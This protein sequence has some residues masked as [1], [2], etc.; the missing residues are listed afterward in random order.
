MKISIQDLDLIYCQDKKWR[1]LECVFL[2]NNIERELEDYSIRNKNMNIEALK[3]LIYETF[4]KTS[5]LAY[6]VV[7]S[8]VIELSR[9]LNMNLKYIES[10][11]ICQTL[12]LNPILMTNEQKVELLNFLIQTV[13]DCS[14]L[15]GLD[16]VPC[17]DLQ[18]KNFSG[19]K[20]YFIQNK[21]ELDLFSCGSDSIL[22]DDSKLNINSR[23]IFLNWLNESNI[24][25]VSLFKG[26]NSID[27]I[28]L[29][30]RSLEAAK[31]QSSFDSKWLNDIWDYIN[32]HYEE[33]SL[34]GLEN[35]NLLSKKHKTT[36]LL[37]FFS[38]RA[39]NKQKYFY[40]KP[41]D[42]EISSEF[43][44]FLELNI[45]EIIIFNDMPQSFLNHP[46]RNNYVND[47]SL[48][49]FN[50][51][52]KHLYSCLNKELY[53][54]IS[55]KMSA[56]CKSSLLENLNSVK[57]ASFDMDFVKI[58]LDFLPI[59]NCFNQGK[60]FTAKQCNY[61]MVPVAFAAHL[62]KLNL[63]PDI[64]MLDTI[65]FKK[66]SANLSPLKEYPLERLIIE[67]IEYNIQRQDKYSVKELF[68]FYLLNF[69]PNS[70]LISQRPIFMDKENNWLKLNQY[71]EPNDKFVQLMVP[72][73]FL[74]PADLSIEPYY[75]KIK[76]RLLKNIELKY[77]IKFIQ[78]I[79]AQTLNKREL[80]KIVFDLIS[81]QSNKE[82]LLQSTLNFEWLTSLKDSAKLYKSSQL[83]SADFKDLVEL[84]EPLVDNHLIPTVFH[85]ILK[86]KTDLNPELVFR[87][88]SLMISSSTF[89]LTKMTKHYD[90]FS[91]CISSQLLVQKFEEK[92]YENFIYTFESFLSY[93]P[94][95]C[96]VLDFPNGCSLSPYLYS[97]NKSQNEYISKFEK[98]YLNVF[99]VL[100][101]VTLEKLIEIL[102]KIKTEPHSKRSF[103]MVRNIL[104][105]IKSTHLSELLDN[106]TLMNRLLLPVQID[107]S[108]SEK[109]DL[110][111]C[112][113]CVYS[114]EDGNSVVDQ[115][116][117]DACHEKELKLVDSRFTDVKFLKQID[118]KSFT[119]TVMNIENLVIENYGQTEE[120]T[121]RI[122]KLL[123]GYKD[124]LSIFKE[125]IQNADDSGAN[126]FKI[127][128]DKRKNKQSRN[129]FK[130]LDKNM[131]NAQGPA[132]LFYND[133]IF[134]E[135][136][137]KAL[138]KLGSG[139]KK[140]SK[141]KI[142]KFG[143]GFN[144]VYNITVI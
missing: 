14:L 47:I 104:E 2:V 88:Y 13:P 133:S 82:E 57:K 49:N 70:V 44:E 114:V 78:T 3:K 21:N 144:S 28:C 18:W 140:D 61:Y 107:S 69:D 54:V 66:L 76:N 108:E 48:S 58:I 62:A 120:L 52:F 91:A 132:L 6:D 116:K 45:N 10:Q 98:L 16:L 142:G 40:L 128:F 87:N 26:K 9:E 32:K 46:Q 74:L 33:P 84:V 64:L 63:N 41:S 106:Q 53:K 130:L 19:F 55:E 36:G 23:K 103:I 135:N 94:A 80:I 39:K 136:D 139:S 73:D 96:L 79:N 90:Y 95:S 75:S 131:A 65:L 119:Q 42:D 83:W 27:F 22:F 121:E 122:R 138:I 29:L 17:L 143:L 43:I 68:K 59:F 89:D 137:F 31:W 117:I 24:G 8:H 34:I 5:Q 101:K 92:K 15:I 99:K 126:I 125:A 118:V 112:N 110:E 60:T 72:E 12:K 35:L 20:I 124:G 93:K 134:S 7:P 56:N 100:P 51:I 4:S 37:E 141:E 11:F 38:L 1:N 85:N 71:Y 115:H 50:I 67:S 113:K 86:I 25:S 97:L 111:V 81:I 129:E 30:T 105:T 109:F 102:E 127:C 123:D 77:F